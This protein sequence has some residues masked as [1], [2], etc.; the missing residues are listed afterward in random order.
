MNRKKFLSAVLLIVLA[1]AVIGAAVYTS[2]HTQKVYVSVSTGD[3][4]LSLAHESI[5]VHDTDNDGIL[6]VNDAIYCAHEKA[7]DGGAVSGYATYNSPD[8][9]GFSIIKLWGVSN[10]G[11]Y[12]YYLNDECSFSLADEIKEGDHVYVFVYNDTDS[13]SDS[14]S[15][16]DEKQLDVGVNESFTLTLKKTEVEL[17][18]WQSSTTAVIGAVITVDGVQVSSV[19]DETGKATVS[20]AEKGKHVISACSP[21]GDIIAPPVCIVNVK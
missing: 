5:R 3:G 4:K 8:Y 12:G 10:N 21:D 1:V 16:F 2:V 9:D 13:Y 19:T 17:S 11:N 15:F 14:Y 6:T 18:A 20:I 7:Y